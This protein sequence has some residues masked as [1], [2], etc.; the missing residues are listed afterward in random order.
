MIRNSQPPALGTP[1]SLALPLVEVDHI[2]ALTE[3]VRC[4]ANWSR[5]NPL[6]PFNAPDLI[7]VLHIPAPEIVPP[8]DMPLASVTHPD[9]WGAGRRMLLVDDKHHYR[10]VISEYFATTTTLGVAAYGIG[11]RRAPGRGLHEDV[12]P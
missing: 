3:C 1:V 10:R 6:R 5:R 8:P 11:A 12:E 4:R 9:G 7:R 2:K